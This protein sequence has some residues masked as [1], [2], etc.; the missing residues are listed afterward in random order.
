MMM[1]QM[2]DKEGL[3][4]LAMHLRVF[5]NQNGAKL[6]NCHAHEI[7]A[8]FFGYKSR[9]SLISDRAFSGEPPKAPFIHIL[10]RIKTIESLDDNLPDAVT[11]EQHI[12][13]LLKEYL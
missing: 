9:A 11:I 1:R 12:L 5:A 10:Q 4:L 13:T 7:V 6:K 2:I 8:A 3:K